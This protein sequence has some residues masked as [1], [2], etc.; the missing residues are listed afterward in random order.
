[1]AAGLQITKLKKDKQQRADE[2]AKWFALRKPNAE[3][4]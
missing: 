1:M 2:I 3:K 4:G